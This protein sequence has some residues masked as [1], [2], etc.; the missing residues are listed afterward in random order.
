MQRLEKISQNNALI[1]V[2]DLKTIN[3]LKLFYHEKNYEIFNHRFS[4]FICFQ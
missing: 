1:F 2:L 4:S 3:S